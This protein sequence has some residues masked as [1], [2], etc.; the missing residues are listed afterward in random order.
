M[1]PRGLLVVIAGP[2]GV[3]KGTVHARVRAS[4]PDATLSISVT[5]RRAR[6]TEVDGV[7]YH[8]VDRPAFEAMVAAGELLEWAEYAGNLY[9]T[10]RAQ[11]EAAVADG[12]VVVLDIEVQGALQVREQAPDALLV[13]LAPPSFAELER[14]LRTRGTEDDATVAARLEV[15]RAELARRDAFDVV[16]IN[17]DLDRCVAEV[18]DTIT[19][20]RAAA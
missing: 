1:T 16:V 9:G 17:D 11:A 13:F 14:R 10:P 4:L 6:P 19:A 5:T 15:A 12:K 8:F 3:G 2:S 20:A 7:H 18:L